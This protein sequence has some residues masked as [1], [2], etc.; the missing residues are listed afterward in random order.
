MNCHHVKKSGRPA[1][2]LH[3]LVCAD[4]RLSRRTDDLLAFGIVQLRNQTST[5]TALN[6]TLAA[7]E[8]PLVE[9]VYR[10]GLTQRRRTRIRRVAAATTFLG[11]Y[12]W[13][14]Y[15]DWTPD[16]LPASY[17]QEIPAGVAA[18][19]TAA[20]SIFAGAA[21]QRAKGVSVTHPPDNSKVVDSIQTREYDL[22]NRLAASKD[23][24][25]IPNMEAVALFATSNEQAL[26]IV[27][28]AMRTPY[29]E[30]LH[31][32]YYEEREQRD[33][34]S[35]LAVIA[36]LHADAAR[37][38]SKGNL[39]RAFTAALDM[40]SFGTNIAS[41]G[42]LEA[43]LQ[44]I[45]CQSKGRLLLWRLLPG[46]TGAEASMAAERMEE[47]VQRHSP[48][49]TTLRWERDSGLEIRRDI[50]GDHLWRWKRAPLFISSSMESVPVFGPAMI[51]V[52]LHGTSNRVV[53]RDYTQ[54]MDTIE[55]QWNRP[56]TPA[57][58]AA[59]PPADRV[60]Q[61]FETLHNSSK[62]RFEDI[63]CE[64]Q[65]RLL[66]AALALHGFHAE[67]GAYP[68][69]LQ[70]LCP[71]YLKEVPTD[72]FQPGTPLRYSPLRSELPTAMEAERN[73]RELVDP[74]FKL[75]ARPAWR[76]DDNPVSPSVAAKYALYSIGPDGVDQFG[77]AIRQGV[78]LA[79]GVQLQGMSATK[80]SVGDIIAGYN[81]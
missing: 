23:L 7:L 35:R 49:Q 3:S 50:L 72:P 13:F 5:H 14:S 22:T 78:S 19:E 68:E 27:Q 36:L 8:L 20:D 54:F 80:E 11:V 46:L 26:R 12:G 71:R 2:R 31:S 61:A 33:P 47:A 63:Y 81:L 74:M 76:A 4:C 79:Q 29:R 40:I 60:N 53:L 41:G 25:V 16:E 45:D 65:N 6:R 15:M 44:G 30:N 32:S 59:T 69:N 1:G 55:E 62:L 39:W 57:A 38:L 43:R 70:A 18:V 34:L 24:S 64:T 75:F 48:L 21:Q 58:Q 42:S 9:E 52:G 37:W 17:S 10:V 73:P 66:A 67:H 28:K 77:L 51:A 56:Y